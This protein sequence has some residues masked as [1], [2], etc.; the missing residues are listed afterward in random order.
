MDFCGMVLLVCTRID[1]TTLMHR[2]VVPLP[3]YVSCMVICK[4]PH[5][6]VCPTC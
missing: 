6:Y 5:L 1:V 2:S 4:G 3:I